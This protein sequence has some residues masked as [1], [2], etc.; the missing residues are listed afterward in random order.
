MYTSFHCGMEFAVNCD[1]MMEDP[2]SEQKKPG[3]ALPFLLTV[4]VTGTCCL[5]L[6]AFPGSDGMVP[7]F[8]LAGLLS[9]VLVRHPEYRSL[10]YLFTL[11]S[12]PVLLIYEQPG[13]F[14]TD[15]EARPDYYYGN[16]ACE[17]GHLN[18]NSDELANASL[19]LDHLEMQ[20]LASLALDNDMVNPENKLRFVNASYQLQWGGAMAIVGYLIAKI[21]LL[22]FQAFNYLTEEEV[23]Q[24]ETQSAPQALAN[25]IDPVDLS[26]DFKKQLLEYDFARFDEQDRLILDCNFGLE[27]LWYWMKLIGA[28]GTILG[29]AA[30]SE[31]EALGIGTIIIFLSMAIVG[32]ILGK[33]TNNYY[34]VDFEKKEIYYHAHFG[35]GDAKIRLVTD[36]NNIEKLSVDHTYRR[37]RGRLQWVEYWLFL[38]LKN[39]D[40]PVKIIEAR[41]RLR[42]EISKARKDF[43]LIA[44]D[45][46]ASFG[47]SFDLENDCDRLGDSARNN[48]KAQ[49]LL[50]RR[51]KQKE[52]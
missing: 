50:A 18:P 14:C 25:N 44:T 26:A 15:V 40:K 7:L 35:F 22:L 5:L 48:P 32:F 38:H 10:L 6:I 4:I 49:E 3:L 43:A 8:A 31:D 52:S 20:A 37:R 23:A 24:E 39:Q 29:I 2:N 11:I 33:I 12:V 42:D 45:L 51:S 1:H 17:Q 9:G 27:K 46:S 28:T 34:F 21:I 30:L 36:F 13:L 41:F 47:R 16:I 19:L